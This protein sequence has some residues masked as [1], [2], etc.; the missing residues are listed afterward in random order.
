L[1]IAG[2]VRV[3]CAIGERHGKRCGA[4]MEKKAMTLDESNQIEELLTIWYQWQLGYFP[5][6]GAGR[7]DPTC[8]GFAENDR[9]STIEERTDAA[10]RKAK[11]KTAEQVDLC[12]DALPWQ[13]RAQIQIHMQWK[14]EPQRAAE[15]EAKLN[16]ECGA[17]V[18]HITARSGIADNHVIYQEAKFALLPAL[19]RRSLIKV[20]VEV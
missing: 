5:D 18:W 2:A 7:V 11:K 12:V 8:R 3:V 20:P 1:C 4:Y 6:L 9:H 19:R 17:S 10:E 16:A 14:I 13:Q 15:R